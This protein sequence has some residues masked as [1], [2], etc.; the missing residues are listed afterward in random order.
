MAALG[1]IRSFVSAFKC[2]LSLSRACGLVINWKSRS[3]LFPCVPDLAIGQL[4]SHPFPP[5]PHHPFGP[6]SCRFQYRSAAPPFQQPWLIHGRPLAIPVILKTAPSLF[7]SSF[8]F[9]VLSPARRGTFLSIAACCLTFLQTPSVGQY[10]LS[11]V[12]FSV[13]S[14]FPKNYASLPLRL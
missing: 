2:L 13:S 12:I 3:V 4:P 11:R 1:K 5:R 7:I 14:Q 8:S 10:D 6:C 9:P